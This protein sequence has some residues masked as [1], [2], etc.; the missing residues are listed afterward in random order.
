MIFIREMRSF[1][2]TYQIKKK[3]KR[4]K[5]RKERKKESRV[6]WMECSAKRGEEWKDV[7]KEKE[8]RKASGELNEI[9]SEGAH[10]SHTNFNDHSFNEKDFFHPGLI[11]DLKVARDRNS[12]T[13]L[14]P[15]SLRL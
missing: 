4:K 5:G 15:F 10:I 9:T 6:L 3:K 7:K 1:F 8:G 2:T 12:P 14:I 13:I 11:Y